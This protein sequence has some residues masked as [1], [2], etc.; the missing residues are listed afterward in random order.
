MKKRSIIAVDG[1]AGSGK[2]TLSKLLAERIGFVHLN[3]GLVYRAVAFL[4]L[5]NKCD[6]DSEKDLVQ[7]LSHHKIEL[8]TDATGACIVFID[9]RDVSPEVRTPE[10]S[11]ATSKSSRHAAVREAVL[12]LQ[13]DAFPGKSLVAEGRDMGTV[14]FPE[15][16]LKFFIEANP[17]IR[18]ERRLQQLGLKG[19]PSAEHKK[20][21]LIEITERD[22]RDASRAVAPTKAASDSIHIDNSSKSL[23]TALDE[24][25]R[26]AKSRGL[27]S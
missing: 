17:N 19:A 23:D 5:K 27:V 2:T 13:R 15:A 14:V 22:A 3:T 12:A 4:A 1:L 7:M 6:V 8:R 20:Q 11:E 24:L 21:M 26:H 25:F 10:V 9:G 16:E 18:V